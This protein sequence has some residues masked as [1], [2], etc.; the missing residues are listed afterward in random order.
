MVITNRMESA[1]NANPIVLLVPAR[2]TA[3]LVSITFISIPTETVPAVTLTVAWYATQHLTVLVAKR[4]IQAQTAHRYVQRTV[5]FVIQG[6]ALSA[7]PISTCRTVFAFQI[8]YFA[9]LDPLMGNAMSVLMTW[10]ICRIAR[11]AFL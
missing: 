1:S 10:L 11:D 9:K 7:N 4:A 8:H 3:T 6:L 2:P 5:Q